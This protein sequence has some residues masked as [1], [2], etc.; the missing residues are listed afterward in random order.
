MP[1]QNMPESRG[2]LLAS[3]FSEVVIFWS[4]GGLIINPFREEVISLSGAGVGDGEKEGRVRLFTGVTG[5]LVVNWVSAPVDAPVTVFAIFCGIIAFEVPDFTN[6]DTPL[7]ATL[8]VG[9]AT[10]TVYW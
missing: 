8:V 1:S 2:N 5:A 6:L 9:V 3:V 4:T 7:A 10:V